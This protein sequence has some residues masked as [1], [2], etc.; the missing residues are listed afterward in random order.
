MIIRYELQLL[1]K[2]PEIFII[3]AVTVV[4]V[5]AEIFAMK[6]Y[7]TYTTSFFLNAYLTDTFF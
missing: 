2:K 4:S 3:S 1:F 7:V 6:F 5:F